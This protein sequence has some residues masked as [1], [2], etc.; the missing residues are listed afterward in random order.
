VSEFKADTDLE[1]ESESESES[2]SDVEVEFEEVGVRVGRI[3]FVLCMM[4]VGYP[5]ENKCSSI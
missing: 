1:V 3:E 4:R 5:P 2:E